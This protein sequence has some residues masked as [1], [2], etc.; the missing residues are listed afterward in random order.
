MSSV[1][2]AVYNISDVDKISFGQII[3]EKTENK[4]SWY[5]VDWSANAPCN[6]YDRSTY[7]VQSGWFRSDTVRIFE[8]NEMISQINEVIPE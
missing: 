7:N 1:G 2:K 4:W 6:A 3:E 5:R 8:P